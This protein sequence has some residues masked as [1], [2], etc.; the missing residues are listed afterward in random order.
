M[1]TYTSLIILLLLT[2]YLS[3]GAWQMATGF[4]SPAKESAWDLAVQ[5]NNF[6]PQYFW[7]CGEFTDS[8]SIG[9]VNYLSN[10]L[11][12]CFVAKIAVDGEPHWVRTFGSNDGD[13]ALSVAADMD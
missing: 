5:P 2:A 12:D 8:L 6:N 4:G 1:K 11:S 10:G 13:V 9:G 3:A 7:V